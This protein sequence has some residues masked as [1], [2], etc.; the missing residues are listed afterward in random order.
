MNADRV[1]QT[2]HEELRRIGQTAELKLTGGIHDAF[3]LRDRQLTGTTPRGLLQA[4]WELEDR[5]KF[6]EPLDAAGAFAFRERIFHQHFEGWRATRAD[7]RYI[8][9]LGAT[10]C[11]VAHDWMGDR[12]RMQGYVTSPIFP[13]AVDREVVAENHAALR[14][15]LN[16]CADFGLGAMIWLTELPCQGGPWVTEPDRQRFLTRYPAEVLSDS[17]SYEGQVLCFSHP[18]VQEYYRDLC[19]RFFGEFPE[20]ETIFLFGLDSSGRF[21]GPTCPRC[22]GLSLFDQRD[23]LIRFLIEH[24]GRRVLTTGWEWD[25]QSD[26]FL[27]R[28][29]ALPAKSGVY[30]AAQKD[31]WQCERQNHS[32]LRAVRQVCRERGQTFIGYDNFHWGDDT[33]HGL[34][35]IQDF[36]LGIGAKLRRWRELDADGVFDHWGCFNE[37]VWSNS[38]ACRELFLERSGGSGVSAATDSLTT[39]GRGVSAAPTTLVQKI[40]HRQFGRAGTLVFQAWQS[41]EAA[42]AILSNACSWSPGQ[43]PMWYEFRSKLRGQ[44]HGEKLPPRDQFNPPDAARLVAEAWAA[45][46]PHYAQAVAHLRAALEVAEDLPVGYA[47]WYDGAT[48]TRREH[49]RRQLLYVESVGLTGR[50][51]GMQFRYLA[52][53]R[54]PDHVAACQAAAEFFRKLGQPKGWAEQ[55]EQK[56][57]ELA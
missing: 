44:P 43:W 33:V 16:D 53:Q 50:E 21:C 15:L 7:V 45:A 3:T 38:I 23:R 18:R 48:I 24:T 40:A 19:R 14:R 4:I 31:G 35:D 46:S 20:I 8:A 57:K 10:H 1:L 42:H 49:I 11:L 22:R 34:G 55:Y 17:G 26:E 52:G 27:R 6:G 12:R 25:R 2:A 39:S 54:A 37:N 56:L 30:L 36:P 32:F 29:A 13:E 47:H 51:I 5:L 9:R 41:L 28:Q